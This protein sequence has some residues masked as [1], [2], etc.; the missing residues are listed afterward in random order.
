MLPFAD[1]AAWLRLCG[2]PRKFDPVKV[3]LR[4]ALPAT[5]LVGAIELID[6]PDGGGGGGGGGCTAEVPPPQPAR[7]TNRNKNE[8]A[9]AILDFISILL[10]LVLDDFAMVTIRGRYAGGLHISIRGS[11]CRLR[12]E[13]DRA[14]GSGPLLQRKR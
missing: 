9:A 5:A 1:H 7:P 14:Q 6:T 12:S 8:S 2:S 3:S 4:S 11:P 13:D 10:I